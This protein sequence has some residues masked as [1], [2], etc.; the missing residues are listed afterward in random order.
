MNFAQADFDYYQR[1]IADM[2]RKYYWKRIVISLVALALLVGYSF[3]MQEGWLLNGLL[4]LVLIGLVIYFY[5]KMQ[6]FPEIYQQF[7]AENTPEVQ[8]QKIQ[9]A[10][11]SYNLLKDGAVVLRINKNGVRN[12]PSNNKTYTMMVGFSKTFFAPQPLQIVFYDVLDLT[13]EESYRLKRNGYN[14]LPRFLRRFTPSNIKN[15]IGNGLSFILGN[16]FILFI[17]F[18]LLRYILYFIR[19]IM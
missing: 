1:S 14:S 13:Y 18:R 4:S 10:E 11:D 6:Q 7:L 8:I 3:I 2:Y 15:S 19:S 17:L 16:L 9:E 12:F 5:Q